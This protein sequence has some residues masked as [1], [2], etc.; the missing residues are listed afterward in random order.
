M[1]VTSFKPFLFLSIFDLGGV[2][3]N[4]GHAGD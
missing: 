4:W 1:M 3:K 2:L